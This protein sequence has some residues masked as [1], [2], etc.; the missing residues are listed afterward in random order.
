MTMMR[1]IFLTLMKIREINSCLEEG[2]RQDNNSKEVEGGSQG[3][4]KD[5]EG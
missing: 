4:G 2:G 1:E 3:E 5:Q